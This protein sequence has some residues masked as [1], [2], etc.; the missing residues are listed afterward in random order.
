VTAGCRRRT[1]TVVVAGRGPMLVL[2]GLLAEAWGRG[3]LLRF[4]V[5]DDAAPG[6]AAR[7]R[8]HGPAGAD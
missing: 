3:T 7:S 4:G 8:S 6:M 1:V 2:A 5:G